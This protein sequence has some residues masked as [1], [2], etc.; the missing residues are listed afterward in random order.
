MQNNPWEAQEAIIK[1]VEEMHNIDQKNNPQGVIFCLATRLKHEREYTEKS[2]AYWKA[3][4][5]QSLNQ[6]YKVI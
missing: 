3:K 2:I 1:E 6:I 4:Y 5:E